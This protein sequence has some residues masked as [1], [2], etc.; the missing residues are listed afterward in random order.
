MAKLSLSEQKI[1]NKIFVFRGVQVMLDKD[2]GEL[3]Q[4][5]TRTLNQAVKRNIDRF[6]EDFMFQLSNKEFTYLISQNVTSSSK[7]GGTRKLP[8]AFTEQGVSM[9]ASILKSEIAV[10]VSVQIIR[11][12]VNMRKLLT[13]NVLIFQRLDNIEEKISE[14]DKKLDLLAHTNLPLKEGIFYD[15]QFFDAWV[16]AS[17]IIKSAKKEIILIDNYIDESVLNLLTKR[18]KTVAATI[19]TAKI[20]PQLKT[21]IEKHN[22]QYSPVNVIAFKKSHDRFLIIDKKTVYHIGA[23]LKD[24]GKK[25][26]AFSKINLDASEMIEKLK[27]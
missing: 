9:L 13:E 17:E 11:T 6:P 20:S 21:D 5:E 4:V 14:H 12:F 8:Y 10:Q 3:Y 25:W 27:Q 23:S 19:Y 24:L 22:T 7:W 15:G 2:L 16:F 18:D 26:F 1:K